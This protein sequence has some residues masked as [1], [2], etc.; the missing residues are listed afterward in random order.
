M[1]SS[2]QYII[3]SARNL[4]VHTFSPK[5]SSRFIKEEHKNFPDP[6]TYTVDKGFLLN[7]KILSTSKSSGAITFG[8]TSRDNNR[9]VKYTPGPGSYR[10]PSEFGYYESSKKADKA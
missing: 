1:K 3:S 4:E 8:L 5:S 2:G 9:E 7:S 6:C 10:L